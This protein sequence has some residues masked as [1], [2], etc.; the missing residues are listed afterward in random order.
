MAK[1]KAYDASAIKW[2]KG[3]DGVRKRMSVYLGRNAD[4]DGVKQTAFEI[5][6]NAL[7]EATNGHGDTVGVKI[8]GDTLT[9]F[10]NGRGIPTGPHPEHK[11]VDTLTILATEMHAGGKLDATDG[12]YTTSIGTNG[13]GLAVV[14]AASASLII[15]SIRGAKIKKQTFAKG[16][17]ITDVISVKATDIPKLNGKPWNV[18]T[19]TVVQW[20]WD[21]TV[22]EKG[23]KLNAA[24]IVQS[25]KDMSWF[26]VHIKKNKRLPI[27]FI[28]DVNKK[29]LLIER[30]KLFN[31]V[32]SL[33][34]VLNDKGQLEL[35]ADTALENFA[36]NFDFVG[37]WSTSSDMHFNS[38]V[39]SVKTPDGGTHLKGAMNALFES[40]KKLAKKGQTFRQQ[41]LFA[42]FIGCFNLRIASPIFNGQGKLALTSPEATE[43]AYNAVKPVIDKWIRANKASAIKIVERACAIYNVTNDMKLQKQLAAALATKKGGKSLLPPNLIQS[44]T[45]NPMER[46]LFTVEGESASGTG[47]KAS[48]RQYQ[49]VLPL[50]GKM[51]N[52]LKASTE[53]MGASQV[54]IDLL[55][56]IGYDPKNREAPLRV[57]KIMVL[58]DPDPDGP[59][60]ADTLIPYI[61]DT[62]TQR[63][64]TIEYL[65]NLQASVDK[66]IIV[67]SKTP[68]GTYQQA[69]AIEVNIREQASNEYQIT[70]SNGAVLKCTE[71][72]KWK[73]GGTITQ[74]NRIVTSDVNG[75]QYIAAPFLTV[76]DQIDAQNE[77]G[78]LSVT[79]I[80]IVTGNFKPYYCM[81]VPNFGNFLVQTTGTDGTITNVVS[82][83]C[84]INSLILSLLWKTVP[85]LYSEGRIFLVNA[86]LFSYNTPKK[87]YYGSNLRDLTQQL[88]S[89]LDSTKVTRMKGFGEMP[90][91]TLKHVAFDP[92]TRSLTRLNHPKEYA[93]FVEKIMGDDVQYRKDELIGV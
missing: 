33:F 6:G 79:A 77:A 27:K 25:I 47:Q 51:L 41:D 62:G 49:E 26:A 29:P 85:H 61:D 53:K 32:Q 91:E 57:G 89:K 86:P 73:V 8:D 65:S 31:Y 56:S 21:K 38:A 2:L 37:A 82:S 90:P 60:S 74:A 81:T 55:R 87:K 43:L 13:M 69:N 64:D 88:G 9:V 46:E 48:N 58:S 19:G 11:G 84:H 78:Y 71:S 83:N 63:V 75:L 18:K 40:F 24:D 3:L 44:I 22:F 59:L 80:N 10:D 7:D 72:H 35:M 20:V 17:P 54:I 66:P 45:K 23:A 42:G 52:V 68:Q 30:K 5:L 1:V 67:I 34:K 93:P 28:V 70:M 39:N 16:K 76:G 12:N 92:D 4:T 36:D 14:N 15:W 50:R